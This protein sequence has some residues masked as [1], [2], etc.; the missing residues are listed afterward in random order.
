[1]ASGV[2]YKGSD[3]AWH[4]AADL[5]EEYLSGGQAG[6]VWTSDGVGAGGWQTLQIGP[7][8]Y[9]GPITNLVVFNGD[10]SFTI[11]KGFSVLFELTNI[12]NVIYKLD[13]LPG[14]YSGD[15]W[16]FNVAH[17]NGGN[18]VV[19]IDPANSTI[20]VGSSIKGHGLDAAY[21]QRTTLSLTRSQ[22]GIQNNYYFLFV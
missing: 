7:T 3:G 19:I 8:F 18:F 4:V 9:T 5:T 2:R 6:Q 10:G 17:Y 22:N 20:E 16:C 11:P 14:T 21:T 1:M 15:E 13:I 12:Y